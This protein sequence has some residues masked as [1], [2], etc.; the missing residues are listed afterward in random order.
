MLEPELIQQQ[1]ELLRAF[2]QATARR[3]QAEAC[4]KAAS[5]DDKSASNRN[6]QLPGH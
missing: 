5:K 6:R 2:R 1:R 3:A 4:Q